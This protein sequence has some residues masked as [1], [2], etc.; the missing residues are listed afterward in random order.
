MTL[1]ERNT[2][3]KGGIILA[4]VCMLFISIAV[5][6]I[7]P[8]YPGQAQETV[9]RSA[10]L[11]QS[12]FGRFFEPNSFVPLVSIAGAGLYSLIT[13]VLI[14]YFF[15]KTQCPEILFFAFFALSFAFEAVRLLIPLKAVYIISPPYLLM[16]FKILLFTRYFG[17][18][19]L[20]TASVYAAGL[21]VQKQRDIILIITVAT[22][23]I[24]MGMPIDTLSWDSSLSMISGYTSMFRMVE[25]GVLFITIVSFLISAY[26]RGAGEYILIGV[27]SLFVFLGR[28]ILLNADTWISL[29]P[30]LLLL[31]AGTWYICTQLH[32]VYLWL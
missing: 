27:G 28:N 11:I 5:F 29:F 7:L 17:I 2:A 25:A 12:F 10:G 32:K 21:E 23:V 6:V 1:W 18:F 22:M 20:F 4:A 24:A 8:V 30:A 15:E 13:L 3:F 19:S 26:S 14:Y 31:A 16:A 9:R